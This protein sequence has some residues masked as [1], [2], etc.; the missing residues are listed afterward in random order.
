MSIVNKS[1]ILKGYRTV[2]LCSN[3]EKMNE[4]C[5]KLF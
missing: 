2:V 5:E 1:F 4:K 3:T